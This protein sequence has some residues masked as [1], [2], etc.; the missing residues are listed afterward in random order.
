M[1]QS[2]CRSI[3][4]VCIASIVLAVGT[5]YADVLEEII[6]TAQK[7][8]ESLQ[9]IPVAVSAF[10]GEQIKALGY[11]DTT[12]IIQQIPALQLNT[13]SPN[14]TIF[15]LRGVSQNN[16]TDNLEAPIAVYFDD[17]YMA[18]INGISGQLFDMERVE[19]LR[20]PQGTL[21]GRNATG[22]LIHYISKAADETELNAYIQVQAGS[23]SQYSTEGALGGSLDEHVR[24][25]LAFRTESID[26]YV[27]SVAAI[28]GVFAGSGQDIG[29]KHGFAT[30]AN[31]QYDFSDE[32]T[33]DFWL[34]F[35][36]DQDVPTGGYVFENCDFDEEGNCPI[37][38]FGRT[39][40]TGGVVN[41][42]TETPASVHEHFGE[43][44]GF[45]NRETIILQSKFDYALNDSIDITSISN[46][47]K[48]NKSYLEDGDAL[49]LVIVNFQTDLDYT[50]WSQEY[51][52]SNSNVEK[53]R[54]QAGLY[55]LD[56]KSYGDV[57]TIAA[58]GFGNIVAS[59]RILDA[60]GVD[61]A[62]E[63]A[64]PDNAF[65]GASAQQTV[66]LKSRNWS[67]FGQA[68]Y[69]LSD[70]LQATL[71]LRWSQDDKEMFWLLYFTDNFN[72]TPFL[73]DSSA[74]FA[75][76]NPGVDTIDY[77]D[78]AGRL[79]LD[80]RVDDDTLLFASINR[81]IKGGNW[82]VSVGS[83]LTADTFQHDAEVLISFEVGI[84]ADID[85]TLRINGTFFVYDYKDYQAFSLAGGA[86]FV[87]NTNAKAVGTEIELFWT[88][89][90]QLDVI[91]GASFINSRVDEV[92]GTNN[93]SILNAELPNA[94]SFSGNYLV[95]YHWPLS[96]GE[97]AIQIDGAFYGDQ[98]LEVT[99]GPGTV[100]KSYNVSNARFE[101][102][103]EG[104][105]S[106][107]LWAKNLTDEE[108]KAYSLDLGPLGT[109][110]FYAPPET[111][112][113]SF[114]FDF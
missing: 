104:G 89:T 1:K 72:P 85:E 106:V 49:P 15:N 105:Y 17:A 36:R 21:F 3:A 51:R 108:Y 113:A 39:I 5:A 44:A 93:A 114:N 54:W 94:P 71:G 102:R 58:P 70:Q 13:W 80:W 45:L 100:Q 48:L 46:Y 67:L 7:K 20:G 40:T 43:Q 24:A 22:G 2:T 86:P 42:I 33:A 107:T 90:E 112:G 69:D 4:N 11:S 8:E 82:A 99:N 23:F 96:L 25:R 19:V 79:A 14:V 68:E 92:L 16:F 29:G 37:D 77:G 64:S 34:K 87:A 6:V 83:N 88:P 75:S 27:K 109:T 63:T 52:I 38:E 76:E 9:D 30:R 50:Q 97:M 98:F 95:R 32:L 55:L 35:S 62:L 65:E 73:I 103:S 60:G 91:L 84:K 61:T 28:P 10:S 53:L 47:T 31:F 12:D 59:G 78:W 81:G 41:G 111:Y 26:G 101:Y 66:N 110:T 57:S 18:S 74:I 56:I